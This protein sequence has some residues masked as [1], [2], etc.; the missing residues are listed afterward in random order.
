VPQCR[1]GT[2]ALGVSEDP[3]SAVRHFTPHRVR[4]TQPGGGK[5]AI[6][7]IVT[8][9]LDPVV[10]ADFKPIKQRGEPEGAFLPHGLPD[11]VRQ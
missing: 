4:G 5:Q 9:G 6:C 2:V 8:T 7:A 11:Q 3:G 1:P 10:H